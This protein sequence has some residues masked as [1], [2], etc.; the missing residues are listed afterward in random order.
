[1]RKLLYIAFIASFTAHSADFI[2]KQKK[3]PW[4][5]NKPYLNDPYT[6]QW[7]ADQDKLNEEIKANSENCKK[8]KS[9]PERVNC[10]GDLNDKYANPNPLRGTEEYV[11]KFYLNNPTYRN[12]SAQQ[13]K[14]LLTELSI[15]RKKTRQVSLIG[16]PNHSE[17]TFEQ[18]NKEICLIEDSIGFL[19]SGRVCLL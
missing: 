4:E 19:S 12:I 18:V 16:K 9:F 15:L 6:K 5:T 17:L 8:L 14:K 13:L 1:M 2:V 3:A 7:Y 10:L 11:D